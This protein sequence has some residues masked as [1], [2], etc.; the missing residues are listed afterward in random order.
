LGHEEII[1]FLWIS[2]AKRGKL[3]IRTNEQAIH[4]R[5]VCL[6]FSPRTL[7]L[8]L[9]GVS[10]V[11]E[12]LLT[13]WLDD[14]CYECHCSTRRAALQF[15]DALIGDYQARVSYL[16]ITDPGGTEDIVVGRGSRQVSVSPSEVRKKPR[17]EQQLFS[18][19][20]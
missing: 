12:W 6:P 11:K 17:K 14:S 1:T 13:M 5:D 3:K 4:V 20:A 16:S 10:G 19:S 8:E 2:N 7:N 9:K 15:A 18:E